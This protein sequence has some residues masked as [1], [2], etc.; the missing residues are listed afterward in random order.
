MYTI[1][2]D[3]ETTGLLKAEGTELILQPH[4]IEFYGIKIDND[5][6]IVKEYETFIKPPIPIPDFITKINRIDNQMVKDAPTFV[7]V[8]KPLV[9]MFFNCHT[10]VAHNLSFDE[11]MLITELKRIGKEYHFPYPPIKFCTVEQSMH[12]KGYRLKNNELYKLATG[13]DIE[14]AHIARNDV[15]ATFESYKWLRSQ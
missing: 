14:G 12:I 13:K 5:N 6:N 15:L 7:E 11:G 2:Y 3:T 10:V 4:I 1:I 8:Y 9:S